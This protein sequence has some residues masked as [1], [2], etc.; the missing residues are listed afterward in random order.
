M[1]SG[2]VVSAVV[3]VWKSS[4]QLCVLAS[5]GGLARVGPEKASTR[6]E[7]CHNVSWLEPIIQH[8]GSLVVVSDCRPYCKAVDFAVQLRDEDCALPFLCSRK[9]VSFSFSTAGLVGAH[10][11]L[12]WA[13]F[14]F[15]LNVE[16]QGMAARMRRGSFGV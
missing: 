5:A 10:F 15:A 14:F 7:V 6:A 11:R 1:D 2:A 8:M 3:E 12:A 16:A 9:P 4:P 13:S